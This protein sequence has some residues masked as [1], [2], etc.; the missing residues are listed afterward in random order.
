MALLSLSGSLSR[1]GA[2]GVLELT[3]S[4]GPVE[5]GIS[6]QEQPWALRL[7]ARAVDTEGLRQ[8]LPPSWGISA[9]SGLLCDSWLT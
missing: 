9:T 6:L 7:E 3:G 8:L 4:V 1:G 2:E 5:A